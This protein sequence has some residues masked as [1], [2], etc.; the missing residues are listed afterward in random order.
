V[1]YAD[2]TLDLLRKERLSQKRA[3]FWLVKA[4]F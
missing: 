3:F 2:Y 1:T 4:H